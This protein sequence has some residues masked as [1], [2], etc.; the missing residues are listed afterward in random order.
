MKSSKGGDAAFSKGFKCEKR[1]VGAEMLRSISIIR[2]CRLASGD[3]RK[4]T[5]FALLT[6]KSFAVLSVRDRNSAN[7]AAPTPHNSRHTKTD[8][9]VLPRPIRLLTIR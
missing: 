1:E 4:T 3:A 2:I 8:A 5:I 7:S 9:T 6:V